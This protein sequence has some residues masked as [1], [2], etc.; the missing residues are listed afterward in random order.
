V[1]ESATTTCGASDPIS[2]LIAQYT[3]DTLSR[4]HVLALGN[5]VTTG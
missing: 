3:W 4:R 1:K 5:T 2:T